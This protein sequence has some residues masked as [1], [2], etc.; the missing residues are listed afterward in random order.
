V[1]V[2]VRLLSAAAERRVQQ[3]VAG[4]FFVLAP[5]VAVDA[6]WGLANG[7]RA[8]GSDAGLVQTAGTAILEP[9]LGT[10]K[11]RIGSRLGARGLLGDDR[12]G[13]AR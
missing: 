2:R 12:E 1:R 10:A 3:L 8:Q 9:A 11:R 7:D 5:H 13:L 4:S 6:V